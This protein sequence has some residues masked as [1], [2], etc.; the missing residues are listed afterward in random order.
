MLVKEATKVLGIGRVELK[1]LCKRG[2]IRT[3]IA[4]NGHHTLEY[5]DDDI[6]KYLRQKTGPWTIPYMRLPATMPQEEKE[7]MVNR[8]LFFCR[9][10]KY[11]CMKPVA[12]DLVDSTTPFIRLFKLHE[13]MRQASQ[14]KLE[15]LVLA[16]STL[17]P[18]DS[19]TYDV[20]YYLLQQLGLQE[21]VVANLDF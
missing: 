7:T 15:R 10:H 6:Y 12:V 13:I 3:R 14:G 18:T 8:M 5:H 4:I 21:I 16:E 19:L 1:D 9:A 17:L 2:V 11:E 20:F